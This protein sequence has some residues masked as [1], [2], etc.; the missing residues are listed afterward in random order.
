VFLV[1]MLTE[2]KL[3]EWKVLAMMLGYTVVSAFVGISSTVAVKAGATH[4]VL[5]FFDKRWPIFVVAG[6]LFVFLG[7]AVL[8][9]RQ[10]ST[11]P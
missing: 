4:A 8:K 5:V 2:W 9:K 3:D 10:G 11:N 6:A 7:S 1:A